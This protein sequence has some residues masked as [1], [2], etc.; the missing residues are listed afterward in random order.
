MLINPRFLYWSLPILILAAQ[1]VYT[2]SSFNQIRIEEINDSVRNVYWMQYQELFTTRP[3]NVGWYSPLLI[4]YNIF[5][6]HLFTAKIFK[7]FL[8]L[9]S[10]YALAAVLKNFLGIKKALIP[11]ITLGLS[12]TFIY[13][14]LLQTPCGIDLLYFPIILYLVTTLNIKK[15]AEFYLKQVLLWAITCIAIMSYPTFLFYLP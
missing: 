6:F 13:Y 1:A 3:K 7:L 2:F 4:I 9:V 14:N 5:G 10:L 15:R 11:L 12:P 8:E